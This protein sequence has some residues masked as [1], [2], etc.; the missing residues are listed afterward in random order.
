MSH[1]SLEEWKKYARNKIDDKQRDAYEEHLYT[2]EQCMDVY[3]EA[4]ESLEQDDLPAIESPSYVEE[5]ISQIPL[6]KQA[7]P[8]RR[9]YED[10]VFHYVVATAMTLL[11]MTSGVFSQLLQVTT[12]FEKSVKHASIT[13]NLLNKTTKIID[14]VEQKDKEVK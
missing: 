14:S 4:I 10:K 9:W 2:C 11:L 8:N 6:E 7:Q 12:E 13:E 1:I 3:M 5:V